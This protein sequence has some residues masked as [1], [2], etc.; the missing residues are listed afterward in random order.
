MRLDGVNL[1]R[2]VRLQTLVQADT[3]MQITRKE[4][5]TAITLNKWI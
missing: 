1:E 4:V 3:K 2:S 5:E